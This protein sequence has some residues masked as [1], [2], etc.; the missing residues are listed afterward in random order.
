[1]KMGISAIT[2]SEKI[3]KEFIQD[4][5]PTLMALRQFSDDWSNSIFY[6]TVTEN[7]EASIF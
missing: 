1:M 7:N 5:E 4:Y 2:I 3:F 6:Q